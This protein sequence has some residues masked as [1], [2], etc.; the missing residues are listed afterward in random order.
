ML[1]GHEN[2]V[3]GAAL[4]ELDDAVA[5]YAAKSPGL[6]LRFVDEIVAARR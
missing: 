6:D 3:A 1:I 5:W 4:A 2:P